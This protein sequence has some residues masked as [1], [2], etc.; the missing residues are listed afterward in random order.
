MTQVEAKQAVGSAASGF[1]QFEA[2][3][4]GKTVTRPGLAGG[5]HLLT[6]RGLEFAEVK[7]DGRRSTVKKRNVDSPSITAPG[8]VLTHA[9]L[10]VSFTQFGKGA[11]VCELVGIEERRTEKW[12][13]KR[14]DLTRSVARELYCRKR[15]GLAH[16]CRLGTAG[17]HDHGDDE[18]PHT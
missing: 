14:A 5:E 3:D 9:I 10:R 8:I 17:E 11:A 1:W 12:L 16:A 4:G 6:A 15:G 2:G 7:L 13:Q 18:N